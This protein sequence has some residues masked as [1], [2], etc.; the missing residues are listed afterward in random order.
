MAGATTSQRRSNILLRRVESVKKSIE[1]WN[2]GIK[3]AGSNLGFE[4]LE[5]RFSYYLLHVLSLFL[6]GDIKRRPC[7]ISCAH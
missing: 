5:G 1:V 6:V 7:V 4:V 2:R 3:V